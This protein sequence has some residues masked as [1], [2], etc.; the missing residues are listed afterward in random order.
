MTCQIEG[1]DRSAH[2]WVT[3]NGRTL[4]TGRSLN[5]CE[6]C[7]DEMTALYGYVWVIT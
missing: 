1:C 2:H 6:K 3:K 5:V 4:Q 7:R